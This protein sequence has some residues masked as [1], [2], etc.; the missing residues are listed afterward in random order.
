MIKRYKIFI[1]LL[2]LALS[3]LTFLGSNSYKQIRELEKTAEMVVHTLRIET[4]INSLFSQYAMMQSRTFENKLLNI[5]DHSDFFDIQ[6]DSTLKIY[7]RLS[8]LT[9]D[10]P[11]QQESLKELKVLQKDF[12]STIIAIN[13]NATTDRELGNALLTDVSA[14]MRKIET[15]KASMLQ[16]EEI[17]LTRRQDQFSESRRLN[18]IM[19]LMLGMFALVI[20][21]ISFWQI[22]KQRKKNDK[23]TQFLESVL[24]NTENIVSY[25]T[26]IM[27]ENDTIIDF[28]I[29]YVNENIEDVLGVPALVLEGKLLSDVMPSHF[30]NGVFEH[31]VK[32]YTL[33][34]TQ[35]FD[36]THKFKNINFRFKTNVVKLNDGIL[37]TAIDTTEE[38]SIKQNL[39]STKDQLENQNLLLLDNRAFLSNIFK[40]TSN[41]VMHFKSIRNDIGTI[42]DFE[43]L[44]IND[45]ISDIIGDIPADV[46]HKKASEIY[47]NIFENGVFEKMVT[48]IEEERQIE[49]ET[50]FDKNGETI[51][52]HA[53]AVKLNDGV[54]VTSTDI[55]LEKNRAEK[56]NILNAELEIQNSIFKDAEGVADIG[57]Y[58]WYL[59]TGS[60]NISDNFYRILGYSP[61]AF[62][63]TFDSYRKF[64]HPDDLER[65]DQLGQETVE[66]GKSDIHTYR[67]ITKAGNIKHIYVNGQ[68]VV[69]NGRSA[70]VG[71]VQDIT[72]RIKTEAK[73]RTKNEELKRSN[74]ELESFNRVASHDLQEPMRK[75][76]MFVSRLSEGELE[77]LS[78]KGKTYFEKIDSS[79]NRMQKLIKYLL[80]YSRI[81]RTKKDFVKIELN[82]TLEKVL[83]D[84]E[85]RI[86][87][88]GVDIAVDTLPSIKA[89]PFQMEQLFTNL[90]SNAIK[91]GSTTEAPKIVIDCKK[92][93][94]NKI[95]EVFDKKRK[96]YYR[97]S[98]MDNGIGFDQENSEK[99]FGLFERLHQKNEYSGTG[100]G[101][102]ICKKIVLNHK[103]HIVA[104]SELGKG[105]TFCVYLP[106]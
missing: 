15:I 64:V 102:A 86:E 13:S 65:Y 79:A 23:T 1:V 54:T 104:Q 73:L 56:L 26:P 40:S 48:C 20:F 77:K 63:V 30:E 43:T 32:C 97:I 11:K 89:I 80:A 3:V 94:R 76:Q 59:D 5:V 19:T 33:G 57:S 61:N 12:Y 60:A 105:S 75:I 17:L 22:N 106:A 62:D 90:V 45:S 84:L 14:L 70:S 28:K 4:E 18:P 87:A 98:I 74:A 66:N 93:S 71:V 96:N 52:F 78:D 55:T 103:G 9:S 6:K 25:Y 44:F 72:N 101:L 27:D 8:A 24:K 85:E 42:V 51:W 82:D 16:H 81:N 38:Y 100:I 34:E 36:R 58:V 41:I 7:N 50:Q 53:T 35:R 2:I 29:V 69:K 91:Y 83:G 95:S 67:I 46:K 37:A 39:L 68:K 99:I 21:I 88:S 10:N 49:Y 31:F 92:L 47:P